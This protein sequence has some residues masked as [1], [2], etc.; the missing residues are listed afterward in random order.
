MDPIKGNA[1]YIK[2]KH[3]YPIGTI[4]WDHPRNTYGIIISIKPERIINRIGTTHQHAWYIIQHSRKDCPNEK[5]LEEDID[6]WLAD[7]TDS[8]MIISPRT[9]EIKC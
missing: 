4:F 7:I 6:H 1:R 8:F 9:K 2:M 5:W 3:K